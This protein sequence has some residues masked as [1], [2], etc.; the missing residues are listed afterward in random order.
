MNFYFSLILIFGLMTM[1]IRMEE[2]EDGTSTT[3]STNN[4]PN[5]PTNCGSV[6][7]CTYIHDPI[8]GCLLSLVLVEDAEPILY[9]TYRTAMKRRTTI[10]Y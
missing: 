4:C 7:R 1:G 2:E 10:S 3:E 5:M 6:Y 8:D 9:R